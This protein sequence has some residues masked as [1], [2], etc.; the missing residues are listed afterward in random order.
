[1]KVILLLIQ[2]RKNTKRNLTKKKKEQIPRTSIL[3]KAL[4]MLL[5]TFDKAYDKIPRYLTLWLLDKRSVL[6]RLYLRK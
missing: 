2:L 1:M 4:H 6:K 5:I 3:K